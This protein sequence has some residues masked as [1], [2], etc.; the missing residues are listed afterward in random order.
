MSTQLFAHCGLH[1]NMGSVVNNNTSGVPITTNTIDISIIASTNEHKITN[2]KQNIRDFTINSNNNPFKV[3]L[4]VG[5][6]VVSQVYNDITLMPE[7][8]TFSNLQ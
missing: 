4:N 7:S 5:E 1:A 6:N 3:T 2:L 8:F